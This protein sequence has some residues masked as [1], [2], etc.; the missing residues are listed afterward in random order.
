MN[1]VVP[2]PCETQPYYKYF[3]KIF[4]LEN[5][6]AHQWGKN[7]DSDVHNDEFLQWS[8]ICQLGHSNLNLQKHSSYTQKSAIILKVQH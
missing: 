3:Y 1:L 7:I 8:V 6:L 4:G 5:N 2:I